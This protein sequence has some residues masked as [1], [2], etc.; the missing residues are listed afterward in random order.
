MNKTV[1]FEKLLKDKAND[2]PMVETG[3]SPMDFESCQ[4]CGHNFVSDNVMIVDDVGPVCFN[5]L[6]HIAEAALT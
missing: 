1:D 6:Y 4:G 3:G 2:R 5:C